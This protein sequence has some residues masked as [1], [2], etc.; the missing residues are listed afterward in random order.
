MGID[1]QV[2]LSQ[3]E[4]DAFLGGHETGVLALA[5]VDE[6]YA[7][8][9]SYG[10]DSN[11]QRF[12]MRLVSAPES[13]KRQFLDSSPQV[14]IVVYDEEGETYRSVVAIGELEHI[15]PGELTVENIEQYGDAKRPLFESWAQP[16]RNLDIE[17]YTLS[18]ESLSGRLIEVD[19]EAEA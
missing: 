9:I 13:E 16:K 5:R 1:R 18:P 19:R 6:P 12:Y 2:E 17:L 15:D 8:P 7:I 4:T 14:R 3:E 10:Y 11:V